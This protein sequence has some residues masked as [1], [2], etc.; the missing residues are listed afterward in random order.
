MAACQQGFS[1]ESVSPPLHIKI[2]TT[3]LY[4]VLSNERDY[5]NNGTSKYEQMFIELNIPDNPEQLIKK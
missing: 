3:C 5:V 1:G 2:D 4:C